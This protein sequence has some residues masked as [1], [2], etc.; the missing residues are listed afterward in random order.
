[1][2]TTDRVPS[3]ETSAAY[4]HPD[5]GRRQLSR[6]HPPGQASHQRQ[7]PKQSLESATPSHLSSLSLALVLALTYNAAA[8]S[9]RE[10]PLVTAHRGASQYLP[11]H[12]MEAY[13]LA[14]RQGTD[15]I[16]PDLLLTADGIAV[17]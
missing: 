12:T 3:A 11:E 14:I 2:D 13:R 4:R 8:Q 1:M 7:G 15:F 10:R 6:A 17:E 16:E 5:D 9:A